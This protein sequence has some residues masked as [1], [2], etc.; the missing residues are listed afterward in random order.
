MT[1]QT[2]R[3]A[4]GPDRALGEAIRARRE[5]LGMTQQQLAEAA[6]V[7]YQQ[8]Q[9]YENGFNRVSF[10]RLVKISHAL[11]SNVADLT[12]VLDGGGAPPAVIEHDRFRDLP[13]VEKLLRLYA[14]LSPAGRAGLLQLLNSLPGPLEEAEAASQ[15]AARA[16][17]VSAAEP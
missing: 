5:A 10:S 11:A 2:R 15:P 8:L 16:A 17:L 6:E 3:R 1:M 13:E 12:C 7:S 14:A 4:G 9:K